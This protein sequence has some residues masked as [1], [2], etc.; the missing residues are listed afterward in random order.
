VPARLAA[1]AVLTAGLAVVETVH[2]IGRDELVPG[3]RGFL[4]VVVA[5]QVVLAMATARRNAGAALGLLVYQVTTVLAA[6]AG[7]F[8]DQRL[9]LAAGAVIVTVL[10]SSSLSAFP[11]I[12]LP[13]LRPLDRGNEP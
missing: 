11:T 13:P 9:L 2:I 7:G 1:A 12:E 5:L 6:V 10:V 3:L 4:V 8:G